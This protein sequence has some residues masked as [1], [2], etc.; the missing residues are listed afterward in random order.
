MKSGLCLVKNGRNHTLFKSPFASLYFS[1]I[2]KGD[3]K[4]LI[5]LPYVHTQH[6][7]IGFCTLLIGK[8]LEN[9]VILG[10]GAVD[11]WLLLVASWLLQILIQ[12]LQYMQPI[13][14]GMSHNSL[15]TNIH[16]SMFASSLISITNNYFLG[17][18]L[19]Y[20]FSR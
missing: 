9:N 8:H 12:S 16:R 18:L 17:Y 2:R 13:G 3:D 14:T 20:Y 4:V 11:I 6:G 5:T 15:I 1:Y 10:G 7:H 19:I